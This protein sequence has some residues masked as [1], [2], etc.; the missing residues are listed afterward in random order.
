[1]KRVLLGLAT[2]LLPGSAADLESQHIVSLTVE[3]TARLEWTF[4]GR[5]RVRENSTDLYQ[6]RAGTL[7]EY[8][9][10]E[11]LKIIAGYYLSNQQD[12]DSTWAKTHRTF[13]GASVTLETR[14]MELEARALCERYLRA[15]LE[16]NFRFRERLR[17]DFRKPLNPYIS[18]EAFQDAHGMP[19]SRYAAGVAVS[20]GPAITIEIGY[21]YDL[22]KQS[23]GGPRHFLTTTF[24]IHRKRRQPE[25]T[26]D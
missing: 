23:G 15:G 10:S 5:T 6:A 14:S 26:A 25:H 18:V 17:M 11:R 21:M 16:D 13:G 19:T 4:H 9:A 1:M 7:I 3:P 22:R 12:R 20:R 2:I 8:G 24:E